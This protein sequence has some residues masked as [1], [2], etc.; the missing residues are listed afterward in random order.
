MENHS[1]IIINSNEKH[2]KK[3]RKQRH[4]TEKEFNAILKSFKSRKDAELVKVP[5]RICNAVNNQNTIKTLVKS[6]NTHFPK[7]GN[8]G[9]T[10]KY[11]DITLI[12]ILFMIYNA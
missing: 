11:R 1:D 8:S 6:Y 10:K 12:S 9:I 2:S 4:V 5:L 7:R 3:N